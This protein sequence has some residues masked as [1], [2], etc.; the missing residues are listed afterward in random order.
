M[1]GKARLPMLWLF[2]SVI[3]GLVAFGPL[4]FLYGP[5]ALAVCFVIFEIFLDSQEGTRIIVPPGP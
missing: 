4:G 1:H 5:I 3:G 2:V